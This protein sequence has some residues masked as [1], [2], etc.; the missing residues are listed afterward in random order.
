MTHGTNAVSPPPVPFLLVEVGLDLRQPRVQPRRPAVGFPPEA[1]PEMPKLSCFS[2]WNPSPDG[3]R[4]RGGAGGGVNWRCGDQHCFSV[5]C[6][7]LCFLFQFWPL[8][9][10]CLV[11]VF[12]FFFFLKSISVFK[13]KMSGRGG[14]KRALS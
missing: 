4:R 8:L 12:F 7:P 1:E 3:G 13:E 14:I 6:A 11:L 2:R 5:C 10:V 9:C